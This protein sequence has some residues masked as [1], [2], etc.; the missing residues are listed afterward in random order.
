ML[1]FGSGGRVERI[2]VAE[3]D[4]VTA[5]AI[6]AKLNTG[7]LE[8][9]L[10]Q[11]EAALKQAEYSLEKTQEP[12]TEEAIE[13]AEAAVEAAEAYQEYVI[14][15]VFRAEDALDEANEALDL[16]IISGDPEA[17]ATAEAQV[18]A[19]ETAL[20]QWQMET[21]RAEAA[22]LSAEVQLEAMLDAPDDG[23]IA[24]AKAQLEAAQQTVAET[25]RQLDEATIRAPFS[26]RVARIYA[27]EGDIISL[28]TII[29][30]I[31]PA[32]LELKVEIDEIDIADVE[33]GQRAIIEVDALPD[34]GIE[35]KVNAV[36]LL[37]QEMGGIVFY[38]VTI[39]FDAASD[40]KLKVGMSATIDIVINEKSNI[41]LI[42]ER[43]IGRDSQG[44]QAV[45]VQIDGEVE[46][47]PVI[48][49]ISDGLDTEIIGGLSEGDTVVIERTESSG[50]GGFFFG[51]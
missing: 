26:G 40:N 50:S 44:N 19:S 24:A 42:P 39:S 38:E 45:R 35:G 16:A 14:W 12:Y 25:E 33:L 8:L 23:A 34:V 29:H 5:G 22:L 3:G 41:L 27:D 2:Y 43:A 1:S 15:M 28:P 47:R 46:I 37:A 9:A 10:A 51:G 6:L 11:A 48:T 13:S 7:P 18:A 36:S 30:L 4:E 31:N 17:I 21:S 49:G 20:E 32:S